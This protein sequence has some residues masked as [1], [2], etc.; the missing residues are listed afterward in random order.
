[1]LFELTA[2]QFRY[3]QAARSKSRW[4][5]VAG[6]VAAP[7]LLKKLAAALPGLLLRGSARDACAYRD[8]RNQE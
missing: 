3:S 5:A 1:M 4:A 8:R 7:M 6:L 2:M